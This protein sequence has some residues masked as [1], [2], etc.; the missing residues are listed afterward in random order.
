MDEYKRT[1][2]RQDRRTA[3]L[4]AAL[5]E[6]HRDRK[7]HPKPFTEEEFMP[8]PRVKVSQKDTMLMMLSVAKAKPKNN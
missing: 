7:A 4:H 6:I 1:E 5:F 8:K 2:S 3:R